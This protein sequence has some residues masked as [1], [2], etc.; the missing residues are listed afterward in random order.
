[1]VKK[2]KKKL[3]RNLCGGLVIKLMLTVER[4]TVKVKDAI[5]I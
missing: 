3:G 4:L 5:N 1:M 2:K